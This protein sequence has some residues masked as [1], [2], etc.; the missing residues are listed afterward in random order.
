VAPAAT[1]VGTDRCEDMCP[2]TTNIPERLEPF[3]VD[4]LGDWLQYLAAV[5]P[6]PHEPWVPPRDDLVRALRQ[7]DV[8]ERAG[9]EISATQPDRTLHPEG[10]WL[11]NRYAAA[12]IAMMGVVEEMPP[13]VDLPDGLPGVPRHL[14]IH[15][16]VAVIPFV[17]A[18]HRSR[19]I[20]EEASRAILSDLGRNVR[21][22]DKRH[23][24]IGLGVANWITRHFRGLIYDLGRLQFERARM[25]PEIADAI[26]SGGLPAVP[27]ELVL[28]VHIPDFKGPLTPEACDEAIAQAQAF[29][30]EHFPDEQY[31][32][33]VCHSWLLDPQLGHYLRPSANIVQFQ[34]RFHLVERRRNADHSIVLFVFG[35]VP[36]D[37]TELP[38]RTSLERAVKEHLVAGKHWYAC[39][40]WFAW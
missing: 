7:L 4:E 34:N 6:T 5:D 12:M 31:R 20:S 13:F 3:A 27:D 10:W 29:F 30:D 25:T 36:D 17:H 37:L 2:L 35:P 28:S 14:A 9:A 39:S 11:L 33:A 16:F 38:A 23:G 26:R 32:Y 40:G 22:H 19:G 24:E 15:A 18:Y 1:G 8:P 21:I